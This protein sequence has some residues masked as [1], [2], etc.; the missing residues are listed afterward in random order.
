MTLTELQEVNYVLPAECKTESP[1][2]R[3]AKPWHCQLADSE[4]SMGN[5][6]TWR[7]RCADSLAAWQASK[8]A[9]DHSN[10]EPQNDENF[11]NTASAPDFIAEDC[12]DALESRMQVQ[13]PL[14]DM[15]N[16]SGISILSNNTLHD[17]LRY[18]TICEEVEDEEDIVA[19]CGVCWCE[20]DE[21]VTLII[22]INNSPVM[23]SHE[24]DGA[25]QNECEDDETD[26]ESEGDSEEEA[27]KPPTVVEAQKAFEDLQMLLKPVH[28]NKGHNA[29]KL[30]PALRE[31]LMHMKNFLWLHVDVGSDGQKH[32]ANPMGGQWG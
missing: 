4:H 22:E 11:E 16:T 26:A 17:K 18:K 1:T 8:K 25:H 19:I 12:M 5:N 30:L 29:E 20:K 9:K 27:T 31:R 15:A 32:P 2:Q 21:P 24:L 7:K 23:A 14:G 13:V 3:A 28:S 10:S 6:K